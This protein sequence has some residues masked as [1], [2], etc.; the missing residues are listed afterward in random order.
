MTFL[1]FDDREFFFTLWLTVSEGKGVVRADRVGLPLLRINTVR[2]LVFDGLPK[3]PWYCG[4]EWSRRC[5]T[6]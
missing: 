6:F 5:V 2:K 1:Y 4:F 3:G